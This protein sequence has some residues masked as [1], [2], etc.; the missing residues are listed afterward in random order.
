MDTHDILD[1]ELLHMPEEA[2]HDIDLDALVQEHGL[3][4][5][6]HSQR[7]Q[8]QAGQ[9]PRKVWLATE[10]PMTGGDV[11]SYRLDGDDVILVTADGQK[12]RFA[13]NGQAHRLME[14]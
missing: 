11:L 10:R 4:Y 14:A 9:P 1:A 5:T 12:W 8:R 2:Q 3:I 13:V 6:D 7:E